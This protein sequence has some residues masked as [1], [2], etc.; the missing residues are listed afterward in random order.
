MAV[1][2]KNETVQKYKDLSDKIKEELVVEGASIKEKESH[3]AYFNNLP[4]GVTKKQVEEV[5]KYNSKFVTASHLAVGELAADVFKSNK[6]ID[7]VEAELG[8]FGKQDTINMTVFREKTYQNHLA[9]DPSEKEVTKHLV[10]QSTVTSQSVKGYGIKAL[11]DAMSEEFESM[12][13]K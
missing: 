13:K 9:K 12:F 3:S 2:F 1:N 4:E 10:M 8:Y 6:S 5:A 11:R 7:Q